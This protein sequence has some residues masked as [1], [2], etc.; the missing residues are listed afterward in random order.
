VL[1]KTE[2]VALVG[3]EARLVEVEVDVAGVG[4]PAFRMVGLPAKSVTEAEQR[5]R[6][7]LESSSERWP[8][9]RIT[10]NLAPGA[11]RKEGAHFDLA[12]AVGTVAADDRLPG[13]S[14]EG[15][16]FIGEIALD[17]SIRS[18][19]G[20]LAA[21]LA[22]RRLGRRGL[23][24][25]AANASEAAIVDGIE[26]IPVST[27]REA[28]GFLR[29]TWS[30]PEV[31]SEEGLVRSDW[32]DL[33]EVKGQA[34]AKKAL[35]VAAAG[36]H[37]LLLIGPPGTGKTMLA[38][39]LPSILPEMSPEEAIEVTSIYSVAGMLPEPASLMRTRPLR[40]PHHHVSMAG[41]IGGGSGLAHPGE[42]SL[43][44][45]GVLFLDEI[46][47]F[48]NDVL[49][50]L[51]APLED[52]SVRIARSAGVV[53]YP[54]RFSLIASMNPCPCGFA[55]DP[56]RRCKCTGLQLHH[57]RTKLSGPLLDRFDIQTRMPRPSRKD[58]MGAPTGESSAVVRARVERARN[59]QSERY[60]GAI[61]NASCSH[62]SL[63]QSLQMTSD[64]KALLNEAVDG[65]S[66]SGR[67]V[68]RVM[69]LARTLADLR[70]HE[71]VVDED[72]ADA[73]TFRF[74]GSR[75]GRAA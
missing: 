12:I 24:C 65:Q 36:G 61:T 43:A 13:E 72:L 21:A 14:L 53:S 10:A 31:R 68:V 33:S 51:R 29:R 26:V 19:R 11:L 41:L 28:F 58:L 18:V 46:P 44:N 27:L 9:T 35:E 22:C 17:G 55:E 50:S 59:L 66:L 67:G 74:S 34:E 1:A 49:E 16:L 45:R 75:E 39:R 71:P 64:A 5:V 23:L 56:T 62:R 60:G 20:V 2:S 42:V 15:W 32:E 8:P 47:L 7:G 73:L 63:L 70:S 40:A 69:R 52:G 4:I 3:T 25:P 6:S 48:R 57:Y 37:N 54:A 30:P 38:R